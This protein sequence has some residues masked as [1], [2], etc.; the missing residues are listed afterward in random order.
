MEPFNPFWPYIAGPLFA[1]IGAGVLR[2]WRPAA[3]WIAACAVTLMPAAP[4]Y[5]LNREPDA[6]RNS[7][8]AVT[9][10]FMVA[11]MLITFGIER[12]WWTRK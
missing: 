10:V 8:R 12:L 9:V 7:A 4:F 1:I 3:Y 6:T 11:P 5:V 2:K